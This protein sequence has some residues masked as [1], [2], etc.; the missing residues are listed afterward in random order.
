MQGVYR[1]K[2]MS[3]IIAPEPGAETAAA[4]TAKAAAEAPDLPEKYRGKTVEEVAEMHSN[5]ERRL[6]QIQNE[7]G[8]LRGLVQDLAQVQR[9]SQPTSEAP[10]SVDVSGDEMIANP[11]DAIRKVVQPLLDAA[12]PREPE[13][14]TVDVIYQ[15]EQNALAN[16]FDDPMAIANTQGFQDFVNRTGGRQ[17]DY[18]RACDPTLG[19]EQVRAARRLLE[20]YQDFS[21]VQTPTPAQQVTKN[22]EAAKAVATESSGPAGRLTT[23]EVLHESDVIALINSNPEKYRSPSFQQTLHAAIREGR[24]IKNG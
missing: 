17:A 7:V 13:T 22:V 6:G 2:P 8:Q 12:K 20:D 15:M 21:A 16:D 9:S 18:Q 24:Y 4:P 3:E 5:S 23:G 11:G 10:V 14:P 19:V 1:H